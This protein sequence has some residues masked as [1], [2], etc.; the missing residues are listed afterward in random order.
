MQQ[1]R[2][3][4]RSSADTKQRAVRWQY[5]DEITLLYPDAIPIEVLSRKSAAQP[6]G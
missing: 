6:D 5:A 4:L 1:V 2:D 3:A